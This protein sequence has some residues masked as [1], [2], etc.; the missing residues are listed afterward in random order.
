MKKRV[1]MGLLM[2][3]LAAGCASPALRDKDLEADQA[4]G[5]GGGDLEQEEAAQA[6]EALRH[7][8][9]E[10]QKEQQKQLERQITDP[11]L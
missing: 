8:Q 6:Q 3:L 4:L 2:V 7:A 9:A 11:T 10:R 5:V 1:G